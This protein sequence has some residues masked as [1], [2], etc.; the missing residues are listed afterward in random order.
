MRIVLKNVRASWPGLFEATAHPKNPNSKSYKIDLIVDKKDKQNI[1]L[2]EKAV[3]TEAQAKFGAKYLNVLQVLKFDKQ[4]NSVRD[5]DETLNSKG[6][7][8]HPGCM[9]IAARRA[10]KDGM[11]E[12]RDQANKP[13]LKE[14]A[15]KIYAGCY[16]N[17]I[18]EIY[19][20]NKDGN[21][22]RCSLLGVQF[23]K[24]GPS[25]GG[26]S[27]ASADEFEAVVNEEDFE[28]II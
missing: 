2:I 14:N 10:E 28:D 4:K 9:V 1:A 5:G 23:A 25:M 24:D 3:N 8:I 17:A 12:V 13:I 21:A 26:S 7:P 20:Q 22:L 27:P 15:G 18:V 11:P 6:D 19:A 16:V